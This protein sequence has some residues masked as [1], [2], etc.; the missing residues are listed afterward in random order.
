MYFYLLMNKDVI[1]IIII[2]RASKYKLLTENDV[3]AE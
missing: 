2:G 3:M 1:I